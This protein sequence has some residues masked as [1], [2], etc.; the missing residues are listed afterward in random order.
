MNTNDIKGR[1]ERQIS[2]ANIMEREEHEHS[3]VFNDD[4]YQVC[5]LCGICTTL[6]EHHFQPYFEMS[7]EVR[8][9]YAD[10]L[11]NHNLGYVDQV[12]KE[13]KKLKL[14]LPRG[15]PNIV[16]YAY[17]TYNVLLREGI[18]YSLEQLS[19]MFHITNFSRL[20]CHIEKNPK[21]KKLFFNVKNKHFIESSLYL[22]LSHFSSKHHLH[23]AVA[24]SKIVKQKHGALKLNFLV[25]ISLY[26]TLRNTVMNKK[27]LYEELSN[28]FSINIR[29]LKSYL[30]GV[31]K[32]LQ[33]P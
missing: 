10:V 15:Y 21:V 1:K 27:G 25:A 29:T 9:E 24:I 7:R 30:K 13:Y 2:V 4:G 23:K 31:G 5:E 33:S 26:F 8:S 28:Y 18:Y 16:L 12:E 11:I 14:L 17:C 22:F 32:A 6:R 20:F 3:Y 19:S